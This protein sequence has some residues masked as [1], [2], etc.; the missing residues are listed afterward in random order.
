ML[1]HEDTQQSSL[2]KDGQHRGC[3]WWL[4]VIL[5]LCSILSNLMHFV[6]LC[7]KALK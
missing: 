4:L 1:S 7:L 6:E 5:F 3:L 2:G